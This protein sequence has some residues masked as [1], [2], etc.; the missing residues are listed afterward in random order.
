MFSTILGFITAKPLIALG[1]S[2]AAVVLAWLFKVIPNDKIQTVAGGFCY[3]LGV[4]VTLGLSKWTWT[5]PLWNKAVEP[6]VIDLIDNV[7]VHGIKRFIEGMR[8]DN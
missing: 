2:V 4:T 1:G 8:S 5:R 6:F 7:L 3:G